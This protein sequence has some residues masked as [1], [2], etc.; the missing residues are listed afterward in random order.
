MPSG[1]Q[2]L[3]GGGRIKRRVPDWDDC[4]RAVE[5]V[6]EPRRPLL[7]CPDER[8]AV[9]SG[10]PRVNRPRSAQ[11]GKCRLRRTAARAAQVSVEFGRGRVGVLGGPSCPRRAAQRSGPDKDSIGAGPTAGP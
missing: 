10:M 1:P 3:D 8:A 9:W 4:G 2:G 7:A 11:D 5:S 6:T